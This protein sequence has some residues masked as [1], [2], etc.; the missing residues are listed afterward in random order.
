MNEQ[1]DAD[2]VQSYVSSAHFNC[3]LS[4]P[5]IPTIPFN[6]LLN[7]AI[8][9]FITTSYHILPYPF[10]HP[11]YLTNQHPTTCYPIIPHSTVGLLQAPGGFMIGVAIPHL[12]RTIDAYLLHLHS[13]RNL[14]AGTYIIDL[15]FNSISLYNGRG[16]EKHDPKNDTI[17]KTLPVGPKFRLYSVL[18]KLSGEFHIGPQAVNL[19][20]FDSAFELQS[21]EGKNTV[22]KLSVICAFL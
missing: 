11:L 7:Y 5:Y 1:L 18:R 2:L 21:A 6:I 8:P 4:T 12:Y 16:F 14:V 15:T 22:C 10:T 20:E 19:N 3:T 9:Y 13:C 17:V